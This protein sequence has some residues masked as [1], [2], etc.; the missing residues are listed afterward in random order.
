MFCFLGHEACGI[1]APRPGIAPTPPALEGKILTTGP[2]GK[3]LD[4]NLLIRYM[5]CKYFLPFGRLPFCFVDGFLCFVWCS[6]TCLFLLL[7]LLLLVSNPKNSLPRLMLRNLL[8]MFS[9]RSPMVWGFMFKYLIHFELISVYGIRYWF[10]FTVLH[11]AVQFFQHC[12]LETL[13]F[14]HCISWFLSPLS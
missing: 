10:S 1:L 4:V 2:L 13:S 6:P 5:I 9:S 11:V 7:F 14:P 8:V 3:S 12:L